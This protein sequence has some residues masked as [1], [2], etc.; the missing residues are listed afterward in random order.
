LLRGSLDDERLAVF[1]MFWGEARA[2]SFDAPAQV[3]SLRSSK[4]R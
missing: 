2:E 4:V 1:R 3:L